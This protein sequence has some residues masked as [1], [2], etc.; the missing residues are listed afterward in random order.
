MTT[1]PVSMRYLS[2]ALCAAAITYGVYGVYTAGY[3]KSQAEATA[4]SLQ[5]AE[6][7][8]PITSEVQ[9][10]RADSR[11]RIV[12]VT[13]EIIRE[14][15]TFVPADSPGLPGGFRVLH[16]AAAAGEV[17]DPSSRADAAP[18]PAQEAA[19]TVID[20]YGS[21]RDTADQLMKL[22]QWVKGVSQ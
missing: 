9:R 18:V 17:P 19:S 10:G 12:T 2:W 16:D 11:V 20:N 6:R 22:Q 4:R 14:V 21:C 1:I 3:G 15:P 8:A 13:K 5:E 7:V